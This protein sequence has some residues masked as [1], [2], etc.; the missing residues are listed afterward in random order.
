MCK[1]NE[2]H[3]L[4]FPDSNKFGFFKQLLC[5]TP[6]INASIRIDF[7]LSISKCIADFS[8]L[9]IHDHTNLCMNGNTNV[10][11]GNVQCTSKCAL[12]IYWKPPFFLFHQFK[13]LVIDVEDSILHRCI[14]R[15][16]S[17]VTSH[18]YTHECGK[19]YSRQE[20]ICEIIINFWIIAVPRMC[21]ISLR[22]YE[23]WK[24]KLWLKYGITV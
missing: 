6:T 1:R 4:P 11:V 2:Q 9:R 17:E 23:L 16:G 3:S 21:S 5:Y 20:S 13:Y 10:V 14:D 24:L 19:D 12:W 22:L 7:F 8:F 18:T 15:T